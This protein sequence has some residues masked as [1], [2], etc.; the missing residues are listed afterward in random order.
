MVIIHSVAGSFQFQQGFRRVQLIVLDRF[1][2]TCPAYLAVKQT[3]LSVNYTDKYKMLIRVIPK[4]LFAFGA[5]YIYFYFIVEPGLNA[6]YDSIDFSRR[7]Q[8]VIHLFCE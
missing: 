1:R 3:S 8:I 4:I 5:E 7:I 2:S 6:M